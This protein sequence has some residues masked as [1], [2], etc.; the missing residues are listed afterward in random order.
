M[1]LSLRKMLNLVRNI[2]VLLCTP[3]CLGNLSYEIIFWLQTFRNFWIVAKYVFY[4]MY[5]DNEID[6]KHGNWPFPTDVLL[7]QNMYFGRNML[8][9]AHQATNALLKWIALSLPDRYNHLSCREACERPVP[10][11]LWRGLEG[12]LLLWFYPSSVRSD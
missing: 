3:M 6:S 9:C 7:K 4:N 11:R 2:W 1:F 5:K 8:R 12:S 10:W